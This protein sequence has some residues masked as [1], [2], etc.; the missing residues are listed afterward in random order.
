MT[1]F[2]FAAET[3]PN[4]APRRRSTRAFGPPRVSTAARHLLGQDGLRQESGGGRH[5]GRPRGRPSRRVRRRR[6]EG[7]PDPRAR[8]GRSGPA[9]DLLQLRALLPVHLP[10][11]LHREQDH[12]PSAVQGRHVPPQA[13]RG[14]NLAHQ[15]G[16]LP[17]HV[18]GHL[19]RVTRHPQVRRR[20]LHL[21]RARVRGDPQGHRHVL[22]VHDVGP[23]RAHLRRQ[24]SDGCVR[25]RHALRP[26]P[27]P[28]HLLHRGVALR[29]V[30]GPVRV[31]RQLLPRLR[32]DKLQHVTAMVPHEDE[33]R[34]RVAVLLERHPVD[35]ALL[36]RARGGHP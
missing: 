18:R 6:R 30:R 24:R 9:R 27:L 5:R 25:R 8:S 29:R 31:L 23:P 4:G 22:G 32:G 34:G 21:H 33:P 15:H 35:P 1:R 10:V 3:R 19:L 28:P 17:P 12:L 20:P 7:C 16:H 11:H 13:L 2:H 14:E 26:L 36:P